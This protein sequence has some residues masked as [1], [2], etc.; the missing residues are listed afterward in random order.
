MIN[1]SNFKNEEGKISLK[2]MFIRQSALYDREITLKVEMKK[3]R[4]ISQKPEEYYQLRQEMSE[5]K[6]E[7]FDIEKC[8]LNYRTYGNISGQSVEEDIKFQL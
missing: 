7:L 1:L 6:Q 4:E 3:Y 8:M 2:K 5:V